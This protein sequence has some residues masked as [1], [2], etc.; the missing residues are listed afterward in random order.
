MSSPFQGIGIVDTMIDI[1]EPGSTTY[2][3]LDR[4]LKTECPQFRIFVTEGPSYPHEIFLGEGQP[5]FRITG[6]LRRH[7]GLRLVGGSR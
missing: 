2:K 7:R 1:P 4:L 6:L 3:F 5:I